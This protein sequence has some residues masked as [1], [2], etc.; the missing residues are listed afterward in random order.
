MVTWFWVAWDGMTQPSWRSLHT[1]RV[2]LP[3]L[4]HRYR[5]GFALLNAKI[6]VFGGCWRANVHDA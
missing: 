4:P 1:S 6:Y 3:S 2:F 5:F